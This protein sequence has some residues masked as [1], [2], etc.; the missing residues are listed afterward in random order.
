M[1]V[2]GCVRRVKTDE[3]T[4]DAVRDASIT[5]RTNCDALENAFSLL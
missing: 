2:T 5:S 3:V 4:S 1:R